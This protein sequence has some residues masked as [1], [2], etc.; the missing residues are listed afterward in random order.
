MD[1]SANFVEEEDAGKMTI[2]EVNR[3]NEWLKAKGMSDAEILDCQKFIAT[4]VGLPK[5]EPTKDDTK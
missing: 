2:T 3:M 1:K 4:G 5:V